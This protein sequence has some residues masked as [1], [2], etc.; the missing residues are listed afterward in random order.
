M[1]NTVKRTVRGALIA[2]LYASITVFLPYQL[3]F[4]P[5]QARFSEALT[6]LPFIMPEAVAG[7]TVGC[8]IA[9]IFGGSVLD[10]VFGTLA[11]FIAAFLTSKIKKIWLCPLPAVIANGIIV[12]AI[13][14]LVTFEDFSLAV[15]GATA[16]SISV[17]EA[18]ICYCMGI[19][20]TVF[21]SR[22]SEKVPFLR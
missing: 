14:T 1:N 7:L 17:S 6:L 13:V 21:V 12:G 4:G 20:L 22:L 5:I 18:V 2:A 16:L 3:S 11:T 9:N 15:Y 8:F 19:P 10:M